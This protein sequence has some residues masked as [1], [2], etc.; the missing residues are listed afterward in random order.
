MT[1]A[2]LA[3]EASRLLHDDAARDRMRRDL[4]EVAGRLASSGDAMQKAGAVIQDLMEGR[5]AHVS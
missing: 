5:L 4:A 3:E 1:G 2:R